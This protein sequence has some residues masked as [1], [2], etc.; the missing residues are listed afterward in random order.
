MISAIAKLMRTSPSVEPGCE[1]ST[2]VA[3]GVRV[4]FAA[5]GLEV[6]CAVRIAVAV[7]IGRA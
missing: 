5:R 3:A 6:A 2:G 1:R 4:A 7:A